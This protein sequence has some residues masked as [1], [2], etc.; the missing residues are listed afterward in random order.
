MKGADESTE[1]WR[2]PNNNSFDRSNNRSI[3]FVESSLKRFN[4]K[5][6]SLELTSSSY[7]HDRQSSRVLLKQQK[8]KMTQASLH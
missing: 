7:L 8:K 4:E 5:A 1:L 2:Q 3:S 6:K